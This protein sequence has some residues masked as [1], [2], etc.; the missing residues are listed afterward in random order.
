LFIEF[1]L[2]NTSGAARRGTVV[3]SHGLIQTPA[4][5]PVGTQGTVKSLTPQ[6]LR[7]IGAQIIL[8]NAY[9]LYLRPGQE[10]VKKAGGLHGF[11]G[12]DRPILTD[13]GGFQV[14]SLAELR[15]IKEEGV[16]FQSHIDGS[17]HLF[18]PESVM[19]LEA[20]LGADIIM[21]FDECIPYPATLE[22]AQRSTDRTTRWARRCRSEFLSLKTGQALFGIVQGGAYP[23]LRKRSAEELLEIGFEGYAIG[24]LAIGEP[25]EQTWEAI[26]TANSVLPEDKPRYMMGVGFPEDI[27]QG[28]SLGVDMFDC[29][30]PTRNARNGSLFTSA[31]RLAMRNAKHFD[32]MSTVD[33]E[34]DCYLCQN[35]SRAYLR[36]LYM[37]DEILASTLGTIHNLRFYLRMM[38]A[39][40]LAIEEQR[41]DQW[42]EAFMGKYKEQNGTA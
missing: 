15:N 14:F 25:K 20:D 9:H 5:M 26:A 32:D 41:F 7:D 8:G 13:S 28:V 23:E 24:G 4:F 19:R 42:R 17:P 16:S 27:I 6:H 36:H 2:L 3:T 33:P 38:E 37:S 29:V 39:I 22:Y 34:C 10:L 18:T 30:M 12:W 31:G 35:F 40:R 21:C 1:K 11:M